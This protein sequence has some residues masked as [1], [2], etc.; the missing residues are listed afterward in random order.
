MADDFM[1]AIDKA[2]WN[3]TSGTWFDYDIVNKKHRTQFYPSN[4]APLWADCYP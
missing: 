1:T 2:L 4:L 3:E